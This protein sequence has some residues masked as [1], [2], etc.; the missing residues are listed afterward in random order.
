[1]I[2]A[3][4]TDKQKERE[5]EAIALGNWCNAVLDGFSQLGSSPTIS[6]LQSV[7]SVA[8]KRKSVAQLRTIR[9]DL[10]EWLRGLSPTQRAT[11]L[12]RVAASDPLA[13]DEEVVV[14]RAIERGKIKTL[15]EY[16][17]LRVWLEF[18]Q[19]D[20]ERSQ[21]VQVVDALLTKFGTKV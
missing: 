1:M 19:D 5:T 4:M 17:T 8:L 20:K 2:C 6:A 21:D 13:D 14:R 9:R 18:A 10:S 7:V 16:E 15:D 3:H 11:V 12:A